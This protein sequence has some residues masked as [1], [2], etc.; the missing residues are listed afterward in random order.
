MKFIKYSL[1]SLLAVLAISCADEPLPFETFDDLKKGAFS[2]LLSTDN[3]SYFF[4]DPDTSRFSFEVEYYSENNGGEVAANEWYVR[5]RN[6]V[7]GTVSDPVL[8]ARVDASGFGTDPN[9]GLPTASF[10]FDLPSSL[11]AMG[12]SIDDVNGGDDIIYDGY[13]IMKDGRRFGPD[14][15][16][17]AVQGGGGFDGVFRFV[18]PLLCPTE[19]AGTYQVTSTCTNQGSGTG[20]DSCEGNTFVG[21]LII[22]QYDPE[23]A[24]GEYRMF[25]FNEER[26]D[27]LYDMSL[28]AFRACYSGDTQADMPCAQQWVL[29]DEGKATTT[30]AACLTIIDACNTLSFK[31]S[32]QWGET[33]TINSVVVDGGTL[34]I[35]W[36]NDY[37]E[38]ASSVITRTDGTVWPELKI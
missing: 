34:T 32:S 5:H 4:T 10:N 16:G 33:Y 7:A 14:N 2:R 15:T 6:K 11:Q 25:T 37:G 27:T 24:P 31:G 19:L 26:P 12:I 1:Y 13:V 36:T 17:G 38:G 3:G 29:D 8:L 21:T 30:P 9:S 20:W 28:G 22:E 18:K 23:G 35:G